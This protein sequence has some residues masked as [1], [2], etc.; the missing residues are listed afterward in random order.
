MFQMS[1]G[2]QIYVNV[3]W[4]SSSLTL[5]NCLCAQPRQLTALLL[6]FAREYH[7]NWLFLCFIFA[8]KISSYSTET[9]D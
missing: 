7:N 8:F 9:I 3:V 5:Q 6:Q 1:F 4:S 2:I